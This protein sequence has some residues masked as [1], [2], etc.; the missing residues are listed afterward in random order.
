MKNQYKEKIEIMNKLNKIKGKEHIIYELN[1]NGIKDFDQIIAYIPY[2][3]KELWKK[4]ELVKL[5]IE[6]AD[7]DVLKEHLAPFFVNNFYENIFSFH[8][9]EE[10]LLYILTLLLQ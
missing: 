1:E 4:P 10:N 2:L 8:C 6:N 9:I 5:I 7:I 3:M